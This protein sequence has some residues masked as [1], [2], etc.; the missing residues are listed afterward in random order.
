MRR[1]CCYQRRGA[2]KEGQKKPV[3]EYEAPMGISISSFTAFIIVASKHFHKQAEG[4]SGRNRFVAAPLAQ[5]GSQGSL[6][7][8]TLSPPPPPL[9]FLLPPPAPANWPPA[10]LH[11]CQTYSHLWAFPSHSPKYIVDPSHTPDLY[12]YLTSQ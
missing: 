5:S 11:T 2:G 12:S 6:R 8:G 1:N 9:H 3:A 7:F 10:F 4:V